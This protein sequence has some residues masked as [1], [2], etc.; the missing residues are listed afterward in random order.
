VTRIPPGLR[1]VRADRTQIE[2][3][4]INLAIN[5]RDAMGR[6]GTLA[7]EVKDVDL[8]PD[9]PAARPQAPRDLRET[10]VLIDPV[11]RRGCDGE[12][13]PRLLQLG[14]FERSDLDFDRQAL[15]P[16]DCG[17]VGSEDLVGLDSYERTS[18][19]LGQPEAGLSR[20]RSDF[21]DSGPGG[22]SASL[23]KDLV[24]PLRIAGASQFVCGRVDA[25][26]PPAFTPVDLRHGQSQ[27]GGL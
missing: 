25:E 18:T 16:G 12:V 9:P 5:G 4:L 27:G 21:Q 17:E 22:E 15:R 3:V 8:G 14:I 23:A 10:E 1:R 2:Q 20:S 26:E 19:E 13:E 7:I 11:K 6:G 24:N